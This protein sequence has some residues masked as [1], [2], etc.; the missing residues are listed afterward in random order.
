MTAQPKGAMDRAPRALSDI[1]V[2]DCSNLVAGPAVGMI[3]GDFGAEVIKIE[4]P[5]VGDGIRKWGATKNGQTLYWKYIS[6]NKKL[7]TLALNKAEGQ[8][9]FLRLLEA[10]QPDVMIE[11]FRP[12]TLE[13]W[14]LGPGKLQDIDPKLV[15][16]RT[17]GFGQTGPYRNRPGFG[18]LAEGMSGFAHLT[19]QPDGPPTLPQFAMAD[20]ISALYSTI[21]A[22]IA[23]HARRVTDG[24][25]QVIDAALL[26]GIFTMFPVHLMEYD[27]LK[28]NPGRIGSR[29]LTS[30]PRNIYET[31]DGRYVAIAAAVDSIVHRLFTVMKRP[32][33]LTDARFNTNQARL[34]NVDALDEIIAPWV[35]QFSQ[36]DVLDV[37]DKAEVSVAPVLDIAQLHADPHLNEREAIIVVEDP[38]LGPLRMHAPLP[39]MSLTPGRVEFAG[40]PDMGTDNEEIYIQRL[41]LSPAELAEYKARQ[42]I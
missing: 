1:R 9:L 16:I 36:E 18:T 12:G 32:D 2:F 30:S 39:R 37:L 11:N 42:I 40:G 3:L 19:G 10:L 25:G 35:K 26:E 17:T 4:Y 8:D 6:R 34:K 13:K 20:T 29:V 27:Q 24:R 14:N 15:L 31:R 28:I 41:G 33:M 7:I 22:L 23:I 21:G 38:E 5:G